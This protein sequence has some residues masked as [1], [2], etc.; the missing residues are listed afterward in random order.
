MS[1]LHRAGSALPQRPTWVRS[2]SCGWLVVGLWC[3]AAWAAHAE[4]DALGTLLARLAQAPGASAKFRE[5]KRIPLLSEPL[6]STGSI[7]FTTP[8]A[9]LRRVDTPE[10]NHMLLAHGRL[11]FWDA[12][13]QRSFELSSMPAVRSLAE[14]FLYVLSGNRKALESLYTMHFQGLAHTA[15]KLQLTPKTKELARLIREIKLEGD[16]LRVRSLQ[17]TEAS[18]DVSLTTFTD[19]QTDRHFSPQEKQTLFEAPRRP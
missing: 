2:V 15:W 5:E 11:D 3:S 17:L 18:G 9:L 1:G 19:V 4:P 14:S 10:A 12:S 7:Y 16:G 13:G 6:V 8:P